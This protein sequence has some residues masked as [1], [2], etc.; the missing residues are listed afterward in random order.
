MQVY[1]FVL[2]TKCIYH[3]D[4]K[5]YILCKSIPIHYVQPTHTLLH[6]YEKCDNFSEK[7]IR[8]LILFIFLKLTA[9]INMPSIYYGHFKRLQLI[10]MWN[11]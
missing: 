10:V 1:A 6:S 11:L 4:R 2:Y 3:S 5:L 9:Q 7:M 8:S